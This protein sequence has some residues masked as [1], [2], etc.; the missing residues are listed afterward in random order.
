MKALVA[1]KFEKSGL[2]GLRALGVEV[3]YEPDLKDEALARSIRETECEILIVRSTKVPA[4]AME[5]AK[6]AL[7]IRAGAGYNTIDVEAASRLGIYVSN[8]PGKN[9]QAVAELAFGLILALDRHIPDNVTSLREGRWNKKGFSKAKGLFGR[10]LGLIGMGRI[11]QEMVTRARAFGMN[12][13][14]YS[15]WMTPD[16][17]AALGIGRA[18]SLEE[19]ATQCDIVSVHVS[20]TNETRGIIGAEF[21]R[22]MRDGAY[23][24]NTSRAEVVH[25]DALEVELRAK[26]LW[27]GLD[28]FEDEPAGG[29]GEY[30]GSLR[31]CPNVYCTHHIGA[32]TDQAQ[33]AVAAETVRIVREF[34]HTGIVPNVVNVRRADASS[35]L[36]VVRHLDKVGV[37]AHV[38]SV[39]K[40]ENIN[41]QEMENIV[42]GGAQAAIAQIAVDRAPSS[43]SLQKIKMNSNVFDSSVFP[44]ER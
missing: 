33:E 18:A 5:Q 8:C 23:F 36:V 17:A 39:L 38:L 7:I 15:R 21:F 25:Q 34:K 1:D 31:D 26:R 30:A 35:H 16:I 40:D 19:L 13:V 22:K 9:S 12:V 2:D 42:L 6:L 27:A 14:A 29:E 4:E 44:I 20:L 32:S 24:I 37:L 10:T 11:G 28:V 41:V 3:E 43:E